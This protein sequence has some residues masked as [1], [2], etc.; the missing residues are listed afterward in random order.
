MKKLKLSSLQLSAKEMLTREQM[1]QVCGGSAPDGAPCANDW[2][3]E[4]EFCYLGIC[5]PSGSGS[6]SGEDP[7]CLSRP[8]TEQCGGG[9]Y[10]CCPPIYGGCVYSPQMGTY[11][12]M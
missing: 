11:S 2:D 6:G 1:K 9:T 5:N 12:C 10:G 7:A 4:S 3:C 8:V